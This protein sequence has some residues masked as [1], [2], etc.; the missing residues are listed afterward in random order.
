MVTFRLNS[1]VHVLAREYK[2]RIEPYTY[3]TETQA[4][5]RA[6]AIGGYVIRPT[7]AYFVVPVVGVSK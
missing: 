3:M 5:K 4:R 2:G 7:R 6:D 1:G